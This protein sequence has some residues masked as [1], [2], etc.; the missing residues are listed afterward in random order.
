MVNSTPASARDNN[1]PLAIPRR[2]L[3]AGAAWSVP[4]VTFAMAAPA[5]AASNPATPPGLQGWIWWTRRCRNGKSTFTLNMADAYYNNDYP[6]AGLWVYNT[7]PA[8]LIEDA[9]LTFSLSLIHI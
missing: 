5:F 7:T 3:A 1:E 8:T 9:T 4:A 2:T 6:N